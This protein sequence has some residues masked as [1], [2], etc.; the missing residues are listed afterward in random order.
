VTRG[1]I[2][3]VKRYSIH[4]GPGIRTTVFLKGCPLACWWCHNP[5]SQSMF[6]EVV[7]RQERCIGC[8]ACEKACPRGAISLT[9]RGYTA[10]PDRCG[11]CG[12]CASVCPSGARELVGRSVTVME[13][14]KEIEK[15]QLFFDESG[16]GVT[17]SGGEPLAQP[18][19]LVEALAECKKRE[20]H[21][22]VDTTGHAQPDIIMGVARHADLFLYDIKHMDSAK[23][24]LYTGV[25]NELILE[26]LKRLASAGS[27]INVRIPVIPGINDDETNIRSTGEFLA[28][29]PG[30]RDVNILPYHGIAETKYRR[31]E[32]DYR[33][34]GLAAPDEKDMK[35][36]SKMLGL[37]GLRVTIGG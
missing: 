25:G 18:D 6:S 5:E 1:V 28:S 26:N 22:A 9:Q 37:H 23:H 29:L 8:G 11:G 36:I 12:K 14:V 30:V 3:D 13:A 20:I 19:F 2:F 33:L 35:R 27:A 34:G 17:F 10:D 15:D 31:F 7:Y 16:G 32:M 4:D 21:T 24:R